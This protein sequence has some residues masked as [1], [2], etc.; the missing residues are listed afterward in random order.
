MDALDA[1]L[2]ALQAALKDDVKMMSGN[3][4]Q[5]NKICYNFPISQSIFQRGR[6]EKFFLS[7]FRLFVNPLYSIN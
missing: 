6:Y 7:V 2:A 5:V 4:L 1:Q 3:K